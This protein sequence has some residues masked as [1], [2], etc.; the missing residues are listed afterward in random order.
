MCD[1]ALSSIYILASSYKGAY[2][3]SKKPPPWPPELLCVERPFSVTRR[4]MKMV[5]A[6]S[7]PVHRSASCVCAVHTSRLL[8]RHG[9]RPIYL[10]L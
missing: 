2:G 7:A 10:G 6:L 3:T 4:E 9:P 1:E 8:F 5:G